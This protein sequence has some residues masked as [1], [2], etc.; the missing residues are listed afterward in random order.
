MMVL[1]H[2]VLIVVVFSLDVGAWRVGYVV[3]CVCG[4]ECVCVWWWGG[5]QYKRQQKQK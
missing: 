2:I 5:G 1:T 3:L 4:V